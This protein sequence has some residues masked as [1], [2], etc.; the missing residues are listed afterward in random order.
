MPDS[1]HQVYLE[2]LSEHGIFGTIII[3]FVLYKFIFSKI[4]KIITDQNYIQLGSLM[5]LLMVFLPIIPSGAFFGDFLL[6][7]FAINLSILY[8]SSPSLNIFKKY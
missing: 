4:K 3:F 7:L 5:Y 6:T 8:S 2:F 1:P